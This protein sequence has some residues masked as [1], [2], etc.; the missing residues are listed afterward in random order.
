M[1]R[2]I[3]D[4]EAKFTDL[5]LWTNDTLILRVVNYTAL[6]ANALE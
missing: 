6:A 1:L 3:L 2:V 5:G 4:L